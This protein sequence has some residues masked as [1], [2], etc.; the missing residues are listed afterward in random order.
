MAA[1]R[2]IVAVRPAARSFSTAPAAAGG[3]S[4]LVKHRQTMPNSEGVYP[5]VGPDV[6]LAPSATVV[7]HVELVDGSSVWYNAVI[8]GDQNKIH[9]G[10]KS[11]IGDRVTITT[12]ASLESGF[13][14]TCTVEKEVTIGAGS[15]LRSCIV[16]AG[17]SVG[18]NCVIG[19]VRSC[20]VG[21]K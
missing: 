15:A 14:A 4:G 19:E 18:E 11:V 5:L 16:E 3:S 2:I 10:F 13:P 12:A 9:V 1:K 6:F 8:R 7:G 17:A 20:F 21:K